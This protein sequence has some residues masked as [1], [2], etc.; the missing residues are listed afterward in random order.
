[1]HPI[2]PS[3]YPSPPSTPGAL[4]LWPGADELDELRGLSSYSP[5][6]DEGIYPMVRRRPLGPLSD[7]A[8]DELGER[9]DEFLAGAVS[10]AELMD[11]VETRA[12]CV[13][14][15]IVPDLLDQP[16]SVE[17]R[18]AALDLAWIERFLNVAHSDK[19]AYRTRRNATRFFSMARHLSVAI[20]R[21]PLLQWTDIGEQY[22]SNDA[23]T[24]LSSGHDRLQEIHLYRVQSAIERASRRIVLHWQA[25]DPDVEAQRD[26]LETYDG[27]AKAMANVTRKRQPGEFEKLDRFLSPNGEIVGH[28]TGSFSAWTK[29]AGYLCTGRSL[30]LG[31]I[32]LPD[33]RQ[34]FSPDARRWIDKITSGKLAP[35]DAQDE[36]SEPIRKRCTDFLLIHRGAA[37]RHGA[38]ALHAPAPALRSISNSDSMNR[39]I[40]DSV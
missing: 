22:P 24:F 4:L 21:H 5:G 38:G 3:S 25:G 2:D 6:E 30:M 16:T 31:S 36:L 13:D 32:T 8:A 35:L 15:A 9:F 18:L 12:I 19:Q 40:Q 29:I 37:K 1:M 33:N 23:R 11:M 20:D 28:A 17:A 26:I 7:F 27:I 34:A 10:A 14:R 39:C